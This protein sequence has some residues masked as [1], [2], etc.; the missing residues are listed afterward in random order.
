MQNSRLLGERHHCQESLA[1]NACFSYSYSATGGTRTRWPVVSS[2][3]TISLSTSTIFRPPKWRSRRSVQSQSVLLAALVFICLLNRVLSIEPLSRFELSVPSMGSTLDLVVYAESAEQAQFTMDVGLKEIDR[4]S[5]VL[6]NYDSESEIS[7]LCSLSKREP[8]SV[9]EDLGKV[10]L[11]SQRWNVLSER[12]FDITVGCLSQVWRTCRKRQH[13]PSSSEIEAAKKRCGWHLLKLISAENK[14]GE[15]PVAV[16]LLVEGMQLDLSGLATGYI[17]DKAFDK[18][19]ATGPRSILVNSGGDIRVGD[20]P[21]NKAGWRIDVAGLGKRSPPLA[22]NVIRNCAVTTSGDLFQFV[23]I[24]GRRYS[25]FI[26][27]E[28]G[29]PIERR[30]S[31]TA[32]AATTLDADAGATALALLG[33]DRASV[34]FDRLPLTEAILV[35]ADSSNHESI[36]MRYLVK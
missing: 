28:N 36:R 20:S 10:L 15:A 2:T 26:D 14:I 7:Q 11:H 16:Q 6:N 32:F 3:S 23:E 5:R 33:I 25:H 17:L 35:E 4:L 29:N 30:Q 34:V 24:D 13:L 12:K 27:P 18:M 21:P 31:V 19:V 22:S 1:L 8:I 9:S